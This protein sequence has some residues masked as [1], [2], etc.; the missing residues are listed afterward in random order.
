MPAPLAAAIP[1]IVAGG[2]ALAGQISNWISQKRTNR[3]N[4]EFALQQ[5]QREKTDNLSQWQMQNEYNAP[6]AQMERLKLGGLNPNLIY[7]NG[8]NTAAPPITPARGQTP[9]ATAP[10]MELSGTFN[11]YQ[12]YQVKKAQLDNLTAQNTVLVQEALLKSAST[13]N[14]LGQ[15]A[16][17][18]FQLG[19][20]QRL[21]DISAD[22]AFENL[23]KLQYGNLYAIEKTEQF[24]A[25]GES[26]IQSA[27]EK[28]LNLR[29][30]RANTE[31]ERNRINAQINNIQGNTALQNLDFQLKKN[32]IN[33]NDPIY[34]RVLGRVLSNAG[35][36]TDIYKAF[37]KW[38]K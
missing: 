8:A 11:A 33:P 25:Q 20:S 38:M 6:S 17:N 13:A 1:A 7:G 32:G 5:Y 26:N 12:D 16:K 18:K 22:V 35:S 29:A 19:Q 28:V 27:I 31:A 23:R 37:K 2:T 15:T 24:V 30:Q 4:R 3:E 10:R 34:M 36:I 14:L 9:Q 21:A